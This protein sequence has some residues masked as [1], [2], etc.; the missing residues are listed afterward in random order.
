MS[1]SCVLWAPSERKRSMR[2]AAL[3]RGRTEAAAALSAW[4]HAAAASR[5]SR[6]ELTKLRRRWARTGSSDGGGNR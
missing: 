3:I 6:I 2:V 5:R 4:W 1:S